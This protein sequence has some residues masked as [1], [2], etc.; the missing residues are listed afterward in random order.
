MIEKDVLYLN[1]HL[2]IWYLV[3]TESFSTRKDCRNKTPIRLQ[4]NTTG[5]WLSVIR[6]TK[7]NTYY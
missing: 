1:F 5:R 6:V 3:R 4:W 7:L 2:F